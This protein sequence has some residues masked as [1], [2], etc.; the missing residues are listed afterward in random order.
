[1]RE[2]ERCADEA[3]EGRPFEAMPRVVERAHGK[4]PVHQLRVRRPGP[5]RIAVPEGRREE[6]EPILRREDLS[7]R[8]M[9]EERAKQSEQRYRELLQQRSGGQE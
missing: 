2:I 9:A 1:M 6:E 7:E 8:L 5:V 3:I 4:A